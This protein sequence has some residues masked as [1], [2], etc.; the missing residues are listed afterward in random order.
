MPDRYPVAPPQLPRNAPVANVLEPLQQNRPLVVRHHFNFRRRTKFTGHRFLRFVGQR[1]HFH[2][3]LGRKPRLHD[4]FATVAG[5]HV[6]RVLGDL[7][8]QAEFF[9][10]CNHPRA[11]HEPLQARIFPGVG[12]HVRIVG[13]HVDFRQMVPLAHFEIVGVVR[14][15][16]LHHARAEFAVDVRIRNHRNFPVHQRQHHR[17]AHQ[18]RVALVLRMHRC[19]RIPQHR[20][21]PRRGHH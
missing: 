5:A 8:H 14:G 6:V 12:V 1:F 2:E 3:P 15:S 18:M 4:R 10:I 11:R 20:F 7:L 16:N 21:R 9:Q 19:R 17:L 13:H